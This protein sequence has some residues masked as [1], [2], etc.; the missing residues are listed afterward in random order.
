M[1]ADISTLQGTRWGMPNMT[2][3]SV[4]PEKD[5][6]VWSLDQTYRDT[7]GSVHNPIMGTIYNLILALPN[8]FDCELINSMRQSAMDQQIA[9]RMG[10]KNIPIIG[11]DPHEY[12]DE[13]NNAKYTSAFRP[14][15]PV[16][17]AHNE[18]Y[19]DRIRFTQPNELNP[20]LRHPMAG[21]TWGSRNNY[22]P[23]YGESFIQFDTSKWETARVE[24]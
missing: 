12:H 24:K 10:Y 7:Y 11:W 23:G 17:A 14:E 3:A 16:A 15:N 18:F 5:K 9:M 2:G 21:H 1:G 20:T 6:P 22:A 13:F 8:P 19:I 4:G